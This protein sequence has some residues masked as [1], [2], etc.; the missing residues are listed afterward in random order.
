MLSKA[1]LT[2]PSQRLAPQALRRT[3]LLIHLPLQITLCGML[4]Y[5]YGATLAWL[6][7][8]WCCRGVHDAAGISA[9]WFVERHLLGSQTAFMGY[10]QRR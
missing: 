3:I 10:E 1:L 8:N 4:E 2:Q 5:R 7:L 9:R 6:K